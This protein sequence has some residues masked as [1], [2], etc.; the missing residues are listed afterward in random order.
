MKKNYFVYFL[1]IFMCSASFAQ[2]PVSLR[3]DI[4]ISHVLDVNLQVTHMDLD[5][6]SQSI[7]YATAGGNIYKVMQPFG[8][9]AY[10]TLVADSNLHG[11][12]YVQG[13]CIRDSSMFVSG[14]LTSNTPLTRGI[15]SRGKL[16]PDGSWLWNVVAISDPY[17]TADYF[18][19]LFSGTIVNSTGDSIYVNSGSRGD[20]G[21]EQTRYGLYSGIRNKPITSVI[22]KIPVDG[23]S[24]ILPDDSMALDTLGL[25]LCKGIRNT[26]DFA[27]NGDGDLFGA[28]NSGDRDM[29]DELN[30]IRSGHHYGFPWIM[31]D[32][33]NPQQ[34]AGFDSSADVMINH[35]STSYVQG[36]FT[37]DPQF[38]QLPPGLQ[39]TKPCINYGPDADRFR[40]STNGMIMDASDLAIGMYSFTAHRSPLGLVFDK[41]SILD[42]EFRGHGFITCYTRGDSTLAG[43]SSLM[44][45]FGDPGEDILHLEMT[46]NGIGD[47]YTFTSTRIAMGFNHPVD[48]V[49]DSNMLYLIEVGYSGTPKLYSIQIPG[50]NTRVGENDE[51]LAGVYPNPASDK[52]MV[53][54][55]I[56]NQEKSS[57]A[58][59]SLEGKEILSKQISNNAPEG[60]FELDVSFF[61]SGLYFGKFLNGNNSKSIRINVIR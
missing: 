44:S 55:K 42:T 14:N 3:P 13:F 45:P 22:L 52:I 41:D 16:Q 36:F 43:V 4:T 51:F 33:Y 56:S 15:V 30:W 20:H 34:F 8:S 53:S 2:T 46:K 1:F 61:S 40:D 37:N 7:F 35:T 39:L 10:D 29:D 9:A 21:E 31:G 27:Y 60:K 26:Y 57:F 6:L 59:Y 18:D 38:P 50:Y 58:L 24:L 49:L 25:I 11:V 28:E 23:D 12:T 17:E 32:A 48:M 19:H 5:P 47:N 54:Y